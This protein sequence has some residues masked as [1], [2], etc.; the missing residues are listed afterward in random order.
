VRAETAVYALIALVS[1]VGT[2]AYNLK[3]IFAGG[4]LLDFLR[5]GY[6]NNPVASLSTDLGLSALILFAWMAREARRQGVKHV[7]AYLLFS[8]TIAISAVFPLFLIARRRAIAARG[9]EVTGTSPLTAAYPV[10][11]GVSGVLVNYFVVRFAM[12]GLPWQLFVESW[13]ASPGAGSFAVDLMGLAAALGV[14]L[15]GEARRGRVRSV[16]AYAALSIFGLAFAL[17][18]FL[19]AL[20]VRAAPASDV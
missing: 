1:L 2:W 14:F 9:G 11:A 3:L 13:F 16:A 12:E 20:D 8:A 6:A 4:T 5:Q 18:W 19:R 17:P 7:W 10:F 15:V